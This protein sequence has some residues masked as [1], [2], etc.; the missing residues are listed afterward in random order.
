M[1]QILSKE[2]AGIAVGRGENNIERAVVF[3]SR[4][5]P[6]SFLGAG[7]DLL[8]DPPVWAFVERGRRRGH[9]QQKVEST[10]KRQPTGTSS[11]GLNRILVL[12]GHKN[13]ILQQKRG[14]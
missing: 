4:A 5:K 9:R 3:Q 6:S 8:N 13:T 1:D 12:S 11:L 10:M 2:Q 7:Y 14:L